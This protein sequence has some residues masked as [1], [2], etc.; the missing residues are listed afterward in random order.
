MAIFKE[1]AKN[2][3][4]L[5]RQLKKKGMTYTSIKRDN[6]FKKNDLG[7]RYNIKGLRYKTKRRK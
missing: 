7:F 3:E 5:K 4:T 6:R 1:R 2:M